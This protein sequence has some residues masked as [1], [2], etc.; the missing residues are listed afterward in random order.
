MQSLSLTALEPHH[1]DHSCLCWTCESL[2]TLT[3]T[4]SLPFPS[5]TRAQQRTLKGDLGFSIA[6]ESARRAGRK[7]PVREKVERGKKK[8]GA[9]WEED[10]GLGFYEE[11]IPAEYDRNGKMVR[12]EERKVKRE[13]AYAQGFMW[14]ALML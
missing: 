13:K 10:F 4:P 11:V 9:V 1:Q 8:S 2:K 5:L 14:T 3:N 7:L 12:K 6:V